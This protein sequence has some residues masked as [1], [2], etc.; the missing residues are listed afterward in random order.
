MEEGGFERI[1]SG[2]LR[3]VEEPGLAPNVRIIEA[4]S[5]DASNLFDQTD[6]L[7]IDGGH[8]M[9]N[10]A[11][12]VVLHA[13]KVVPGGLIIMDDVEWQ[14][15]VPTVATLEIGRRIR[16]FLHAKGEPHA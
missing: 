11:E 12:D 4:P 7:H 6:Y 15:T 13:K 3:F 10:A 14:S 1:K 2:L 8:S 16:T 5:D 9:Y